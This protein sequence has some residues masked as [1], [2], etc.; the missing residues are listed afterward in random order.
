MNYLKEEQDQETKTIR[1][2]L[3]DRDEAIFEKHDRKRYE[4]VSKRVKQIYYMGHWVEYSRRC[5]RNKITKKYVFLLDVEIGFEKHKHLSNRTL[6]LIFKKVTINKMT[7]SQVIADYNG[8]ISTATIHNLIKS[9]TS[10]IVLNSI[11][12]PELFPFIFVDIDDTFLKLR[13]NNKAVGFKFRVIHLYQWRDFETKQFINE[14][15]VVLVSRSCAPEVNDRDE[16]LKQINTIIR[17]NYGDK[18]NFHVYLSSD[19]A[20]NLKAIAHDLNAIHGIDLFHVLRKIN[21]TFRTQQLKK[22][23]WLLNDFDEPNF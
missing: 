10:N 23:V 17:K 9:H 16:T 15:K 19:G 13:V 2:I 22:V 4:V 12:N 1:K 18:R 8:A 11:I 14:I 6:E 3:E 7:F 21:L 20:R 5:Y